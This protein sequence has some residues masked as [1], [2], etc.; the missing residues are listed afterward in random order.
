MRR[1]T[2]SPNPAVRLLVEGI[3]FS[4]IGS[5]YQKNGEYENNPDYPLSDLEIVA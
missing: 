3:D 1:I 2:D 4:L 5:V